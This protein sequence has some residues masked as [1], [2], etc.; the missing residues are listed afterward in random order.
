[1]DRFGY[2][3]IDIL[4]IP[5]WIFLFIRV[6]SPVRRTMIK[7]GVYG[8]LIAV[9]TE[10]IFIKD[11]WVPPPISGTP[12]HYFI[13]DFM[14]GFLIIGI[15]ATFYD[16][17]HDVKK[18]DRYP[19]QRMVSYLFV[20]LI[21]GAFVLFSTHYGYVSTFVISIALLVAA[22]AMV[23]IRKDLLVKAL[24]S[25]L[26]VLLIFFLIHI[27]I[28]GLFL[29]DWWHTYWLLKDRPYAFY[30]LNTAWTEYMWYLFFGFFM[31]IIADF[32]HGRANIKTK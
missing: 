9:A 11:Y 16:W 26:Y 10:H 2:F 4:M 17:L 7:H 5:F 28:F 6:S 22:A 3:G 23:A 27:I 19:K 15:T 29:P 25:G 30:I 24:L 20:A 32:S 12:G 1:M 8:G 21:L 18:V 13:E 14:Y 31:S